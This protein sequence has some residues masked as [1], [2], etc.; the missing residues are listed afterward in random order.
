[1]TKNKKT[2]DCPPL[3]T[4]DRRLYFIQNKFVDDGM[5][6]TH[7]QLSNSTAHPRT[8]AEIATISTFPTI[9]ESPIHTSKK[10][11]K[12]DYHK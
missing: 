4:K 8:K 9:L 12:S 5:T 6:V 1:M 11:S 10:R 2:P 3:P 7:K